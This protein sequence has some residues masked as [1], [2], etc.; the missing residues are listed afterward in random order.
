M[1]QPPTKSTTTH[2]LIIRHYQASTRNPDNA[3]TFS[4]KEAHD[5]PLFSK[6]NK[7][8]N[9]WRESRLDMRP[10][11]T[12]VLRDILGS[13]TFVDQHLTP[14]PP[15]NLTQ[16]QVITYDITHLRHTNHSQNVTNSSLNKNISSVMQI[17]CFRRVRNGAANLLEA[18]LRNSISDLTIN[19]L[20]HLM[21][22]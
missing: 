14:S 7:D 4:S 12:P 3:A 5:N 8:Q 21:C 20:F 19:S 2:N 13:R 9:Y 6:L 16:I 18:F 11:D 22:S 17:N 1:S 10:Y 15:P